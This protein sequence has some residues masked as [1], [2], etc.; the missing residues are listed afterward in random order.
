M[1][2]LA[3]TFIML[4]VVDMSSLLQN[5]LG[6]NARM[7]RRIRL[8]CEDCSGYV[9][10]MTVRSPFGCAHRHCSIPVLSYLQN[11]QPLYPATSVV[12]ALDRLKALESL[13][14]YQADHL[15]FHEPVTPGWNTVLENGLVILFR[16]SK[17]QDEH[18]IC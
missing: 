7:I 10:S 4:C 5:K 17:N 8:L 15:S 14:S 2:T 11:T 13:T 16:L 18:G 6:T 9:Y 3:Y 1:K 12:A